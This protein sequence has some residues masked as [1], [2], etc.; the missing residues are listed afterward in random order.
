MGSLFHDSDCSPKRP[1]HHS[2]CEGCVCQILDKAA[3]GWDCNMMNGNQTF[4][5]QMKGTTDFIDL[6]NS[7]RTPTEFTLMNFCPKTCCAKFTYNDYTNPSST[8]TGIITYDC[9]CLCAISPVPQ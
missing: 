9:R 4:Y 6:F 1:K 3:N 7:S 8:R 5:L 2:K